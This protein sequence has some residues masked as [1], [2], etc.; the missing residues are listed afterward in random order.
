MQNLTQNRNRAWLNGVSK[1]LCLSDRQ[2]C[3][4]HLTKQEMWDL[5]N[6]IQLSSLLQGRKINSPPVPELASFPQA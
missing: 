6:R 3:W 1:E 5:Q 4:L 2:G